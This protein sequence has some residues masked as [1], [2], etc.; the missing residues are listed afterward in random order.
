MAGFALVAVVVAGGVSAATGY[1]RFEN[2]NTGPPAQFQTAQNTSYKVKEITVTAGQL[3]RIT[4]TNLDTGVLHN[5]AVYTS[6]PGGSPIWT[7]APIRGN[8][9]I[10]YVTVFEKAGT[11]AFRCDFHPTAMVGTFIVVNP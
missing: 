1:R 10:T 4:F 6:N 9:Q 11:F 5:I 3:A 8:R 2:K 7:G